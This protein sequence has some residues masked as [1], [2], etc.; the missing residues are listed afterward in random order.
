M[1]ELARIDHKILKACFKVDKH[2]S[3][4]ESFCSSKPICPI[5]EELTETVTAVLWKCDGS[6]TVKFPM[7]LCK[8]RFYFAIQFCNLA[9]RLNLETQFGNSILRLNSELQKAKTTLEFGHFLH[10]VN[11]ILPATF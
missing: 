2:Q 3:W 10:K 11:L 8:I 6:T 4:L 1:L 7:T 9:L 5:E